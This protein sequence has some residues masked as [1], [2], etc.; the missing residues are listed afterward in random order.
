MMTAYL[1]PIIIHNMFGEQLLLVTIV[2][3]F[4]KLQSLWA[5]VLITMQIDYHYDS[6]TKSEEDT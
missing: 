3:R 6:K 2:V 4:G 5:G 1:K